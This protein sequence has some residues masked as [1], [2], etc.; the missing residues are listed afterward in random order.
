MTAQTLVLHEDQGQTFRKRVKFLGT[1]ALKKGQGVCYDPD[2]YTSETGEAITD[3]WG[4]RDNAVNLP[5]NSNNQ[6]FAGVSVQNYAANANGQWIEIFEPGSVCEV[7]T[8]IDTTAGSTRLTCCAGTGIAGWFAYG[9]IGGRGSALALQTKAHVI[10]EDEAAAAA[11]VNATTLTDTGV[12][13]ADA[14]GDLVILVGGEGVTAGLYT[15]TAVDDNTCTLS[16]SASA[17]SVPAHYFMVR[18]YPTVLCKLLDGAESGLQEYLIPTSGGSTTAMVGGVSNLTYG[19]LAG[20]DTTITVADG[21]YDG[22]LKGFQC[23][24][25][26][27]AND[28]VLSVSHHETTDPET[29]DVDAAGENVLLQWFGDEWATIHNTGTAT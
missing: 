10:A 5:S 2:Y 22:L 16:A 9:K 3:A 6:F 8:V 26:P 4:F 17:G 15:I 21:G 24:K 12:F 7:L 28:W 19:A 14:D 13:T 1:G 23:V 20:G 18:S 11:T 29:F 25:T 27:N